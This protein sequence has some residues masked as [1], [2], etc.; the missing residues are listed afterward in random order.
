MY[1]FES[2]NSVFYTMCSLLTLNSSKTEFLIAGLKKQ[3]FK[4]RQTGKGC[5]SLA[6]WP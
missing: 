5:G 4:N 6:D 3:L 2:Y 1:V